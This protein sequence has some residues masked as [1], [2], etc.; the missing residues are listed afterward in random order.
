MENYIWHGTTSNNYQNKIVPKAHK[1][2]YF[3]FNIGNTEAAHFGKFMVKFFY[4]ITYDM[5]SL[6]SG[7]EIC[8]LKCA[9]TVEFYFKIKKIF[10][11]K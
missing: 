4:S 11:E 1:Q 9:Q 8:I 10:L 5:S 3:F 2:T 6:P 7:C